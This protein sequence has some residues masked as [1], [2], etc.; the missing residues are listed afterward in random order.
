[1]LKQNKL[2]TTEQVA[3]LMG[4]SESRVRAKAARLGLKRRFPSLW[5]FDDDEVLRLR[6]HGR[7]GKKPKS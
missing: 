3:R 1:M 4:V 6:T 5:L 2:L 7:P